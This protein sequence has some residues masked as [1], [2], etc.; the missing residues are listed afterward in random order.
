MHLY[1]DA[2]ELGYEKVIDTY[3]AAQKHVDQ[4]ISCTL[5]YKNTHTT[6]DLSKAYIYAWRKGLKTLYYAR[7]KSDA[8]A[9]TEIEGCVSCAV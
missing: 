7:I 3:A 1:Q 5:F 6:R 9:G 4:G 2:Y 8:L